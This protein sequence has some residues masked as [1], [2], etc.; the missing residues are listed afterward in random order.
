MAL[1]MAAAPSLRSRAQSTPSAAPQAVAEIDAGIGP[2]TADF[3]VNDQHGSPIYNAKIRVHLSY[4][5]MN[6]HKLD[7][8]AGTNSAGKARFIG[9]PD[10]PKQGIFFTASI[11]DRQVS[12]FDDPNKNCKAAFTLPL[13]RTPPEAP[14]K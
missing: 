2:C 14:K 5:F 8:E 1:G 13:E 10:H 3:T 12:A 11:D 6:L 9:L 4:G 7:M